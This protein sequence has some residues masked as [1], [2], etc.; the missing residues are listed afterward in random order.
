LTTLDKLIFGFN[1]ILGI[2]HASA[3]RARLRKT[4]IKHDAPADVII[5]SHKAGAGGICFAPSAPSLAIMKLLQKGGLDEGLGLYPVLPDMS[6]LLAPMLTGGTV[7]VLNQVV[8]DT[9]IFSRAK[10]AV[11]AGLSFLGSDALGAFHI[12]LD[13]ELERTM[14]GAPPHSTL[15]AVLLHETFTDTCVAFGL[16]DLVANYIQRVNS[17]H[18]TMAGF[19]TRN[20]PQFVRFCSRKGIDLKE[21][22]IMTPFNVLGFQMT[23]SRKECEETLLALDKSHIILMSIMAGGRIPLSQAIEYLKSLKHYESVCVGAS[24]VDHGNATFLALNRYLST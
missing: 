20:L 1:P 3:E 23:P 17:K 10:A 5:A 15:K 24:T 19:V 2:D 9:S 18:K 4:A 11:G 22:V 6:T 16:G 13:M 21:I 14:K 8:R 7:T 12:Y